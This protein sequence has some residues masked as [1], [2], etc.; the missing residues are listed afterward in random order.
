[1]E[2]YRYVDNK[3]LRFGYTTGSCAAAAAKAATL[4]LLSGQEVS[5]INLLTPKG[6][7]L[8][9]DVQNPSWGEDF[10]MCAIRKDSGDDPD[11]TNGIL[12]YAKVSY[13]VKGVTI[14]GG[15]GVGRVTRAGLECPVGT[16]AINQVPRRMIEEAVLESCEECGYRGGI[17]VEVSIPDGVEI[18]KKTYNPR[19]GITGGISV[20]GTSGIVE[21]MSEQALVDSIK[22]EMNMLK[23]SGARYIA[24]T[25]GN[26]GE[27]YAQNTLHLNLHDAVKC[28]NFVGDVLDYAVQL[29]FQGVLLVGHLG[30]FVKLAGGVFNTHSRYADCRMEILAAHSAL[31]GAQRPLLEQIMGCITTDEAIELIE[32]AQLKEKVMQS[33]LQKIDDH[34]KARTYGELEIGAVVFSN[35]YGTLGM[36]PDAPKLMRQFTVDIN[37]HSEDGQ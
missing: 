20:L 29:K 25:P 11:I 15:V 32:A 10:A 24:V 2:E 21:P 31:A 17:V 18:A 6:F 13:A 36:T 1:M 26:Y 12:V 16:A 3:K 7:S 37:L 23:A 34:I 9:L 35:R 14:D 4:M 33:I 8:A 30:K 28:S 19:L 27:V 22:V 5:H